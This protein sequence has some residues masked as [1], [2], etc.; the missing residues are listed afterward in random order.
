MPSPRVAMHPRVIASP[1]IG[2]LTPPAVEHQAMETVAQL[3]EL[4]QGR[5]PRGAVNAA[6]A[7]RWQR[8]TQATQTA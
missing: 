3:T 6:Q 8:A 4:L 5:A 2:G 1:H 7:V